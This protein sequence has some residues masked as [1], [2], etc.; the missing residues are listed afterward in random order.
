M[1]TYRHGLLKKAYIALLEN[2]YKQKK[3]FI[4]KNTVENFRRHQLF[5]KTFSILKISFLN[6]KKDKILKRVAQ[7]FRMERLQ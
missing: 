1:H 2:I 6:C 4:I 5:E 3:K 7:D